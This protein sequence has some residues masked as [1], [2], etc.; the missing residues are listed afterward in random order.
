M[1]KWKVIAI[2]PLVTIHSCSSVPSRLS[3]FDSILVFENYPL[4]SSID[5]QAQALAIKNLQV[6][7]QTNFPLTIT[8]SGGIQIPIKIA[9]DQSLI[10]SEKIDQLFI[11][12]QNLLSFASQHQNATLS[13]WV[14]HALSAS[15]KES[16]VTQVNDSAFALPNTS[17]T[18]T[19]LFEEQVKGNAEKIALSMGDQCL[20]YDELN[21]RANQL[22]RQLLSLGAKQGDLIGVCLERS[23]LLIVALLGVQK[24]GAAY[25]PIDPDYPSHRVAYMIEDSRA[26]ILIAD[27]NNAKDVD[28]QDSKHQVLAISHRIPSVI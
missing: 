23:P 24:I 21:R 8:A 5:E 17:P 6:H 20:T 27:G 14:S 26:R 28:S 2:I 9:F 19:M 10:P 25:V 15:E 13:E 7:E 3:L 1:I 12:Y 11:H 16:L 4:D 18:L 22:A